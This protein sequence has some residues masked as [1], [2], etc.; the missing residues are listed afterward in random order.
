MTTAKALIVM[1]MAVLMSG[2]VPSLHPLYT[3]DVL[4]FD[5]AL[6][7]TWAKDD[8]R[9]IFT[10]AGD[11]AYDL[12]VLEKR[13]AP[14]R[15]EAHLVDLGGHR[16]LDL[17]PGDPPFDNDFY[18]FHLVP[19]HSISR[20]QLTGEVLTIAMLNGEWLEKA[21]GRGQVKIA[22]EKVG[23]GK[24]ESILL[25]A[26]PKQLQAFVLQYAKDK[27]AFGDPTEYH[28]VKQTASWYTEAKHPCRQ[29]ALSSDCSRWRRRFG[30]KPLRPRPP[31]I[32]GS[33]SRSTSST[34]R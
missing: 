8:E 3:D 29:D 20:L 12:V 10:K 24:D 1:G 19:A 27:E 21:I 18:K 7:G 5:P 25:T 15:F 16:F 33:A 13:K 31:K 11:K 4:V 28:A 14:A 34:S 23:D 32:P 17:S 22:H 2:C 9:W 26:R 30:P 6:V